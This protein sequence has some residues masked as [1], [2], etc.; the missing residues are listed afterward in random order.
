MAT[1]SRAL[2]DEAF[3][4]GYIEGVSAEGRRVSRAIGAAREKASRALVALTEWVEETSRA[5]DATNGERREP[6]K[7]ITRRRPDEPAR[8][9][10]SAPPAVRVRVSDPDLLGSVSRYGQDILNTLLQFEALGVFAV[11]AR[12]VAVFADKSVTS[13]TWDGNVA[14]LKTGGFIVAEGGNFGLTEHG[15]D[16]A[17]GTWTAFSTKKDL[18]EAW[19]RKLPIG[20]AKLLAI[21]LD[22]WPAA[23]S[24]VELAEMANV[25]SNSSTY[26][27]NV[28]MLRR[29]GLIVVSQGEVRAKED[30]LFPAALR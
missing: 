3:H 29:L 10:L 15:R 18:H 14:K 4:A 24:R 2:L 28:S 7:Q 23:I 11:D 22:T 26:D 20:P 19:L 12:L 13:S 8:V 5:V 25:S 17:D 27:G 16:H 30:L 9:T 6:T 21:V 1:C